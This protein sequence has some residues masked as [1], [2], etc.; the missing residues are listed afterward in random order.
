M[1]LALLTVTLIA[2]AS[3]A[4]AKDGW[5]SSGGGSGVACFVTEGQAKEAS[6]TLESG[7][8]LTPTMLK[9]IKSLVTLDYWEWQKS[10]KYSLMAFK[11]TE[12]KAMVQETEYTLTNLTPLF[13]YR[14]QQAGEIIDYP[15]WEADRNLSRVFDAKPRFE[16]PKTCVQVQLIE[17]LS[18]NNNKFGQGPLEKFPEVL[19]KYNPDF[20]ALL[21]PLNKAILVVHEKMYLIGQSA[22]INTSDRIRSMVMIIF[23]KMI[24]EPKPELGMQGPLEQDIRFYL[25]HLFGG[26]VTYFAEE[27]KVQGAFGTQASRFN[28]FYALEKSLS[29]QV[30]E[31]L[32][33][34][35]PEKTCKDG[36]IFATMQDPQLDDE[37]AFVFVAHHIY[38][39]SLRELNAEFLLTPLKDPSYVSRSSRTLLN[40][41][42]LI[43]EADPTPLSAPV[44]KKAASYCAK[45]VR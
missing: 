36:A 7:K 40:V 34:S 19:L 6:E 24:R 3:T 35:K 14:M 16:I 5:G 39:V 43:G 38:D 10:G 15:K 26:Y 8:P 25:F 12:F 44:F 18:N 32:A 27:Q 9:N 17:R 11:A 30:G 45:V 13:V 2:T 21:N 23:S 42:A 20:F 22:G 31:C 4:F 1:K 37:S 33:Q 28:T 29:K 41:C